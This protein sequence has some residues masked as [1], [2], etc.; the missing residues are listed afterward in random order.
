MDA[1][2]GVL[3]PDEHIVVAGHTGT[4]PTN[5]LRTI[6]AN[7]SPLS[8]QGRIGSFDRLVTDN[9]QPSKRP[10]NWAI[11]SAR[12]RRHLDRRRLPAV[13]TICAKV[14]T[15]IIFEIG[16]NG[17]DTSAFSPAQVDMAHAKIEHLSQ[18]LLETEPGKLNGLSARQNLEKMPTAGRNNRSDYSKLD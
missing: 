5:I 1:A 2:F 14:L 13:G 12:H 18:E 10:I 7:L 6:G 16:A 8:R 9:T 11:V 4:C 3:D 17:F 15:E